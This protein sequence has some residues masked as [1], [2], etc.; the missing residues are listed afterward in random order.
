MLFSKIYL[1][2]L[3]RKKEK[4]I[5]MFDRLAE[6]NILGDI[7]LKVIPAFDGEKIDDA[8]EEQIKIHSTL[9]WM[10]DFRTRRQELL[11]GLVDEIMNSEE[12]TC[13]SCAI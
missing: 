6:A 10:R 1:I 9:S 4:L 3:E 11:D 7:P 12:E 5:K 13:E 8:S 2:N